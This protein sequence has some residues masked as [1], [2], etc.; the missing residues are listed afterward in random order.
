M[1]TSVALKAACH[2]RLAKANSK[3]SLRQQL[4]QLQT[5]TCMRV[6]TARQLQHQQ[7]QLHL[8]PLERAN[9]VACL[10]VAQHRLAILAGA[11]QEVAIWCDRPAGCSHACER[12]LAVVFPQSCINPNA[13]LIH[14]ANTVQTAFEHAQM[15]AICSAHV[16][17]SSTIGRVCPWHTSGICTRRAALMA[18]DE[19]LIS[20]MYVLFCCPLTRYAK[21][22]QVHKWWARPEEAVPPLCAANAADHEGNE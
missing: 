21:P 22:N 13:M 4:R 17:S 15:M 12:A 11:G 8:V 10:A 3:A 7:G 6:L 1:S 9:P 18:A 20:S 14:A 16:Y 19:T 2:S 5:A